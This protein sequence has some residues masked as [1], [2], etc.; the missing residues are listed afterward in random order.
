MTVL[1]ETPPLRHRLLAMR[2]DLLDK[3]AETEIVEP[4]WLRTLAD[5]ETALAAIERAEGERHSV[6]AA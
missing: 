2:R 5:V 4:S 1:T 6:C 3:L